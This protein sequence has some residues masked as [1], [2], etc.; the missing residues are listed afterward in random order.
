MNLT[1]RGTWPGPMVLRQGWAKANVRPWND[2][3]PDAQLRLVRGSEG[4]IRAC[5]ETVRDAGATGVTSPPVAETGTGLWN[6]AGFGPYLSL[7]LYT[8]D[9][10]RPLNEPAHQVEKESPGDWTGPV[11]I[12]RAAFEPVWR[13]GGLGLREAKDATPRSVFLSIRHGDGAMVGFAIVGAG[14]AVAYLQRVAVHPDHRSLG[15]GRSLVRAGLK[16][17]RNHGGRTMLLNTQRDN[18]AAAVLYKSEGFEVMP[19]VLEVLRFGPR[20]LS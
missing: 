11:A 16:W 2:D 12:D 14:N 20:P 13:L 8:R 9:L 7:D 3:I 1:V 6:R 5:A 4:F 15:Y 19:S 10:F 17:G 18:S